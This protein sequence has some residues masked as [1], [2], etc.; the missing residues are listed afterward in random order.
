MQEVLQY[1][2]KQSDEQFKRQIQYI[3]DQLNS[4]QGEPDAL[5]DADE[6]EEEYDNDDEDE[7]DDEE[8]EEEEDVIEEDGEF[9]DLIDVPGVLTGEDWLSS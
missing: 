9:N 7:D 3:L 5:S 4:E 1:L 6:D 8:G 2:M